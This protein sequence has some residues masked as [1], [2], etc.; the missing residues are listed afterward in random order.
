MADKT[1]LGS[2][3]VR[4]SYVRTGFGL[5]LSLDGEADGQPGV[6]NVGEGC[7]TLEMPVV[8]GRPAVL[9][10]DPAEVDWDSMVA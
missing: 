2:R 4:V 5:A 10:W 6:L 8:D 9:A 1:T 7:I 3:S